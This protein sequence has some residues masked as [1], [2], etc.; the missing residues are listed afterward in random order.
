MRAIISVFILLLMFSCNQADKKKGNIE[1]KEFKMLTQEEVIEGFD[2]YRTMS[3]N[4]MMD[5]PEA[6]YVKENEGQYSILYI[7]KNKE[8]LERYKDFDRKNNIKLSTDAAGNS[9]YDEAT[10]KQIDQLIREKLSIKDFCIIGRY[11]PHHFLAKDTASSQPVYSIIIPY[12]MQ[13][14]KLDCNEWKHLQ[15]AK[16][17]DFTGV[18]H[19]QTLS[20]YDELLKS[21]KK[22]D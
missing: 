19:Y 10:Q 9:Y 3:V 8:A 21:G 15:N 6:T 12:E 4:L 22:A 18:D 7:P 5:I 17:L 13:I 11:I 1:V 14:Y 20:T 16:I 2:L